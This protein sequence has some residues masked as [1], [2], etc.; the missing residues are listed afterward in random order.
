M[1]K[2]PSNLAQSGV[3]ST[4]ENILDVSAMLFSRYG[5]NGAG[6]R[7]IAAELDMKAGS[8][9]YHF[10]SK[11]SIVLEILKVGLGNII[12]TVALRVEQLPEGS[13]PKEVLLAAAKGH[14]VALIEKRDY[15][16][17]GLH[18]YGQIPEAA[19]QKG[20]IIR[21]EYERMWSNW[22]LKAQ[23]EGHI[24][25]AVNLKVLRI[26]LL[27]MLNK[28]L[29]WYKDGELDIEEIAEM[30]TSF[31]WHGISTDRE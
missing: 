6:L 24:K 25:P 28:T 9:Y 23:Q 21:D 27:S 15:T 17:T 5:Y 8:I 19:Q 22:L 10:D 13:C 3:K 2:K 16:A 20:I 14:L 18:N 30:Q 12:N 4:R 29:T 26:S 1:K 31:I 11:E 7:D